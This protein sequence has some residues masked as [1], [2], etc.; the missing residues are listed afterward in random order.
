MLA[1]GAAERVLDRFL[2]SRRDLSPEARRVAAE[3]IFGVGLWRRRLRHHAGADAPPLLLLAAL[4]RDLAGREDAERLCALP[5]GAL[6]PPLPPPADL[7]ILHSM[8]DWLA[9]ELERAA[10]VEA[11][12]LAGA[13]NLP[14]PVFLRA[15]R[16]RT[17]RD[18]LRARLAA[19]GVAT[20][21]TR[22]APDG[23]EV[24]SPRPNLLALPAFRDGLF[25]V[26][27]E[28]S[29]LLGETVLARPGETV[30]D[31][32]AGAGGKTLQLAAAVGPDG[33]VHAWDPDASR[34]ARLR[35]RA[36][37]AGARV[38]VPTDGPSADLIV[39]R[40][41]VDAPCSELG[42]LRRGP[43]QRFRID[44]AT[45]APLPAL[46]L[47]ILERAAGHVR[48]GGRL[49]HA[50]CTLRREENEEVARAFGALRPDFTP[51]DALPG[52]ADDEGFLRLLPPRHGT[53][54]FFAAAWTR[55]P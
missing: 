24:T 39:D 52:L 3:A 30:L 23:L 17:S 18:A 13:L 41:L 48:P 11:P 49:V 34:L 16:A 8:P 22:L 10:G 26:Q 43:D 50:T 14:G 2:R 5:A 27:D 33:T 40:V 1:G 20:R 37:R 46:Q 51:G 35:T 54:G 6:P 45:F 9:A 25:E 7:A 12:L 31:L 15:N 21:P 44:P 29:Q 19:E 53:D 36:A 4:L 28:G 38:I 32:C 47:A 55:R 42:V